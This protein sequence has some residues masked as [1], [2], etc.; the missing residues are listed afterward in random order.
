MKILIDLTRLAD[1]F[2]GI[3]RY[4]AC[5]TLEM[6]KEKDN[7]YILIFKKNIHPLFQS[8]AEDEHVEMVVL[9]ECNK[10]LFNQ[11]RLPF[12]ISKHKVD[13]YLFMAFPAPILLFRKN[14]LS[15]IHDI[16]CWDC[17]E[18]MTTL[19]KWYFRISFRVAAL[20]CKLITTVSD[21]SKER[22]IA[23]L[24]CSQNKIFVIH[25]AVDK[26]FFQAELLPADVK[27]IKR[28]YMLPERYFLSLS[29]LEPRKNLRLLIDSY[30]KMVAE[31]DCDIQLVLV[32]RKGWKIDKL[33]DGID[34]HVKSNIHFTGFVD[35]GDLPAIYREAEFFVFPSK[36]E[37]FGLPPLEAMACGVPVLSS[38][39]ASMPE[40]LGDA[41]IY[42]KSEDVNSLSEKL[43]EMLSISEEMRVQMI[44]RESEQ[45]KKFTWEKSA[46]ELKMLLE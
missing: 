22:I 33:L 21:F 7:K 32:G 17:P 25:S 40:V 29:T 46:A 19:S 38:D 44:E 14:M 23:K 5:L 16:C 2:S 28:K 18:T 12:E 39:A 4:A 9:P 35:D 34:E 27:T 10:L 45:A 6:L 11:L 41:A 15:T 31:R 20:K 3:E 30:Q 8:W 42:F 1:H 13:W 37:G 43:Q 26:K 36:Y 24:K